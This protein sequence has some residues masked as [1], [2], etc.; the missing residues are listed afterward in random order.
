MMAKPVQG[1]QNP[2][3]SS[4]EKSCFMSP[5]GTIPD[6]PPEEDWE[7]RRESLIIF[8]DVVDKA[9][10]TP[11]N[12]TSTPIKDAFQVLM[13]STPQSAGPPKPQR[14]N[15]IPLPRS[16]SKKREPNRTPENQSNVR[17]RV[18]SPQA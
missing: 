8:K 5:G 16:R 13:S 6:A 12:G 3:Q 4:F 14:L 11:S 7:N 2:E 17:P 15:G 9:L 18:A 10:A 1:E